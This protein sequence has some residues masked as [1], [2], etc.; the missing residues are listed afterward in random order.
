M[1]GE[2]HSGTW[3]Y[4]SDENGPGYAQPDHYVVQDNRVL[5][6]ECKLSQTPRAWVQMRKLYKPL[7]EMYY[8][9]P[10]LCIQACRN[11]REDDGNIISSMVDLRDGLTWHYIG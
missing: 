3:L 1:K 7:L 11:L 8:N 9:L 4:F 5:L 10:V 2:L 6:I